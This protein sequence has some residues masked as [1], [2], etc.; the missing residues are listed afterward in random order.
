MVDLVGL[1]AVGGM[2]VAGVGAVVGVALLLVHY[3]RRQHSPQYLLAAL[4]G[5]AVP[6]ALTALGVVS[7]LRSGASGDAAMAVFAM[8]ILGGAASLT[9][10]PCLGLVVVELFFAE[11][12]RRQGAAWGGLAGIS[13]ALPLTVLLARPRVFLSVELLE[14]QL[15][16]LVSLAF[17]IGMVAA[18]LGAHFASQ[19]GFIYRGGRVWLR[20]GAL[21]LAVMVTVGVPKVLFALRKD[22]LRRNTVNGVLPPGEYLRRAQFSPSADDRAGALGVLRA[23]GGRG[24]SRVLPA[25]RR[26]LRDHTVKVREVAADALV[27]QGDVE[28]LEKAI[29][30][31]NPNVRLAT[32]RAIGKVTMFR[33]DRMAFVVRP[34]LEDE[35]EDVRREA[36]YVWQ[37]SKFPYSP[38]GRTTGL[39]VNTIRDSDAAARYRCAVSSAEGGDR[40]SLQAALKDPR[41]EVRLTAV[42]GI[43]SVTTAYP[44]PAVYLLQ[45]VLSDPDRQVR[46]EANWYWNRSQ[47]PAGGSPWRDLPAGPTP[48]SPAPAGS[49][50]R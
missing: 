25:M 34:A 41:P 38:T 8:I 50:G 10:G 26:A 11:R 35:D 23:T 39:A 48:A 30:D 4:L 21:C 6:A 27:E 44:V 46:Y 43:G 31:R 32:V 24:D 49:T 22:Y 3:C 2:V 17:L 14:L 19:A 37:H 40:Q 12:V 13:L 42:R 5:A 15:P 47:F 29:A 1:V 28:G 18:L 36:N 33:S 16:T 45:L 7:A 9:V 20:H